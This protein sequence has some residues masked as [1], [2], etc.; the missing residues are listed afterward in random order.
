MTSISETPGGG[1]D[2]GSAP[3]TEASAERPTEPPEASE[4][5]P[6]SGQNGGGGA[7][8]RTVAAAA[9]VAMAG[10]APWVCCARP[11]LSSA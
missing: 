4:P 3:V 2:D 9:R 7:D 1:R 6:G 10:T 5:D 11:S 8:A